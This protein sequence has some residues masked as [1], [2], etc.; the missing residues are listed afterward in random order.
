MAPSPEIWVLGA[1]GFVGSA[2]AR[3]LEAKRR[4]WVGVTRESYASF[5]GR[6]C[7]ILINAAGNSRKYLASADPAGE[8]D[9]GVVGTLRALCDFKPDLYVH[10]SSVDVYPELGDP[11]LNAEDAPIDPPRLSPYGFSKYLAELVARRYAR[12]CLI[13]RLG[14]MVG[15]GLK[16]NPIF[17]LLHGGP[18]Y[19]HPDS[20]YQYLAASR[21]AEISLGMIENDL[22]GESYNVC[23][24]GLVSPRQVASWLGMAVPTAPAG[25]QPERY[26]INID[27]IR[28]RERIPRSEDE[29]RAFLRSEGR[30]SNRERRA[31]IATL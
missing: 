21:V 14:G 31:G 18:L 3:A 19:V 16:K 26:E 24:E 22:S 27:K 1:K 11:R 6:S 8:F 25:V 15:P 13:L 30:L 23:G 4:A 5:V 7:P 28:A 17:D 20:R 10:L 29:V 9:T 12:K 2:I